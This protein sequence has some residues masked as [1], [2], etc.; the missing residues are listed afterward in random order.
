MTWRPHTLRPGVRSPHDE[1]RFTPEEFLRID[2]R[3]LQSGPELSVL[4]RLHPST[5]I[6]GR[7]FNRQ[8]D[9]S[10]AIVVE[11]AN[12]T[13]ETLIV[14]GSTLLATSYGSPNLLS[15]I[16][17]ADLYAK[18]ARHRVH[19]SNDFGVSNQMDFEVARE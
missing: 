12:A 4:R 16:V 8:A 10:A 1:L 14:M 19:L 2:A 18:P 11:C 15:A 13:P 9:G 17:P 5:V 7:T 3:A 6:A